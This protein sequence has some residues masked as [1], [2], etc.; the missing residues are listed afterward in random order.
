MGRRRS[1]R[2]L[3]CPGSAERFRW[4]GEDVNPG[5]VLDAIL[6]VG[7]HHFARLQPGI[8]DGRD[9]AQQADRDRPLLHHPLRADHENEWSVRTLLDGPDRER[10]H[11]A[12]DV[13]FDPHIDELA[14]PQNLA[15]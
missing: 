8:H 1:L 13:E 7:Y 6:A 2:R 15:A 10:E 4:T 11:I 9:L 5:P 12:A 3:R 14:R